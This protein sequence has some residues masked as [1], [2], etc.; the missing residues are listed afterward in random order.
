MFWKEFRLEWRR[1][2]SLAG[3][4]LYSALS[5]YLVGIGLRA[6]VTDLVW[7]VFFWV[8]LLFA[9]VNAIGR[10]FLAEREGH[11]LY[12]YGLVPPQAVLLAKLLFN[13]LLLCVIALF[14]FIFYVFIVRHEGGLPLTLLPALLLGAF[15]L[16]GTL[17]L[18]S[19]LTQRT[20]A[21]PALMAVLSLPLLVPQLLLLIRYSQSALLDVVRWAELGGLAGF[22]LANLLLAVILYPFLWRE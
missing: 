4:L 21:G 13:I 14:T 8:I 6:V 2:H 12:L 1:S 9:A 15:S 5:V 10:S 11:L 22:G 17:T 18:M 16:S 7:A 3:V 20:G 19:A